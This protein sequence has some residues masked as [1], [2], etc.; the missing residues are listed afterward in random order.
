M[1]WTKTY[2]E[3]TY[4]NYVVQTNDGGFII[5]GWI[6]PDDQIIQ[7]DVL[8]IKT[9]SFGNTLWTKVIGSSDYDIGLCVQQIPE[10][11]IISGQ[12][13]PEGEPYDAL[14]IKTDLEG[15]VIWE[16]TF[17]GDKSDAAFS[18]EISPKGYFVTGT[19]NGTWWVSNSGDMWAFEVDTNGDLLWERIFDIALNDI[20]WSGIST[21]DYGYAISGFVGYGFGGDLWQAKLARD[22]SGIE[23]NHNVPASYVLYQ[24]FP[25]P[26]NPITKIKFSI[27]TSTLNPSPYQGEGQREMLV[28]VKVYDVQGKEVTTL[29]SEKLP[30]GNYETTFNANNL[31]SGIYYYQLKAGNYNATKKMVILK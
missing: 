28:T 3:K 2:D 31:S 18:V 4:G 15:N 7:S 6:F 9:D 26:F 17:G 5:I 1:L 8:L 19:T 22:P 20:A 14:I 29:V 30:A 12:T 24:N 11:Y 10:G 16:K 21:S 13:K 27:P 25:N 23:P